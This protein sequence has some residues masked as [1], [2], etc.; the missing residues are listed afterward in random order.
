MKRREDT[1][2]PVASPE[3]KIPKAEEK[4]SKHEDVAL[5]ATAEFFI[6]E[7][8]PALEIEGKVVASLA[9]EG[10]VLNLKKGFQ[11]FNFLMADETIKHF[12]FQSTN[13]GLIGLKR[14]RMYE[15]VISYQNQRAVTTYVLF[16]GN[17]KRPMTEFKEGLNT[18]KVEPII[19]SNEDFDKIIHNL[20]LKID[21][22]EPVTK[23]DLLPL[24]LSPLMGGKMTHKERIMAAY[25]ITRRATGVG[26]CWRFFDIWHYKRG[27]CSVGNIF[28]CSLSASIILLIVISVVALHCFSLSAISALIMLSHFA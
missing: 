4:I 9:T 19:L 28:C 13:E 25:D 24:C 7:I 8:M 5:K 18:Y 21:A 26:V 1:L 2:T 6:N 16:S 17:I 14:F 20:Q 11:N 23:A 3:E 22:G 12:E 27:H 15:A 10:I